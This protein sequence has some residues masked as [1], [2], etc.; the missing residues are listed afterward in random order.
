MAI[1]YCITSAAA[2]IALAQLFPCVIDE[3]CKLECSSISGSQDGIGPSVDGVTERVD[4]G[5]GLCSS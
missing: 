3:G 4:F 5:H 1:L 2:C